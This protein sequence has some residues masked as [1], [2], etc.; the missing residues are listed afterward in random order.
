M[1]NDA[2]VL[3][4]RTADRAQGSVAQVNSMIL[5]LLATRGWRVRRVAPDVPASSQEALL[6][7]RL[8]A[9]FAVDAGAGRADLAIYDDGGLALRAPG[10][11]WARRTLVL[12]HGLAYGSGAWMANDEIDLHCANSPYLASV[13]RAMFAFPD[14]RNRCCLDPRAVNAVSDVSLP[15]PCML[16]PGQRVG[17]TQGGELPG[18]VQQLLDGGAVVGHALQPR[19]QDLMATVSIMYWLNHIAREHGTKPVRLV[20]SSA[21]LD[22]AQRQRIDA[23]LAPS[24]F[25]CDD[26]FVL[27]GQL[28]Q[29][30][31]Y[32]LMGSSRFCLAYNRFPEPFGFYPLE[33]VHFGCPVYTNGIGNNRHLLP[34]EHGI[35]VQESFEMADTTVDAAAYRPVAAR[36]HADLSRRDEVA[37]HCS[38]GR[39]LIRDRWSYGAFERSFARILEQAEVAAAAES[40]FDELEVSWSPFVRAF[41]SETGRCLNDYG[42][43][44]LGPGAADAATRLVGS[45]CSSLD[46]AVMQ[47]LEEA[48][49]LFRCG[50]LGLVPS[51]MPAPLAPFSQATAN[52]L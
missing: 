15:L 17:F 45:R 24:G 2:A 20:L 51:G 38:K 22:P 48:H 44:T 46:A 31:L 12:Y 16:D 47:S 4:S 41:D 6:P 9:A 52:H 49:G 19:K 26:F 1:N 5:G 8:A 42:N 23:M 39:A 14:W 32:H 30:A 11:R 18:V 28:K 35:H 10:R 40:S 34:P 3:F 50:I 21:S 43:V 36:I 37:F 33:S 25:R 29:D 7:L 27:V 13:L